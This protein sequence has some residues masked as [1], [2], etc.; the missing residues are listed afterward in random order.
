MTNHVRMG[1]YSITQGT[2]EELV[3]Q[4]RDG[5]APILRD[6]PGFVFYSV[7]DVGD[8]RL[9]SVST[10]ESREQAEAAAAKSAEWVS[11][12][13]AASI[14]LQENLIGEMTTLAATDR[15]AV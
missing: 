14:S 3:E 8:G 12:N 6:S 2:Y 11:E 4:A 15:S 9:V 5:L 7:S 13:M 1:I 10:W